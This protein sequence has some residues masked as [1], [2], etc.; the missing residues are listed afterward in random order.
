MGVTS[1]PVEHEQC[2]YSDLFGV[3][4]GLE[5]LELLRDAQVSPPELRS[6]CC[7]TE[8]PFRLLPA[9]TYLLIHQLSLLSLCLLP[10]CHILGIEARV[11]WPFL[12]LY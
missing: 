11:F 1:R 5:L 8:L 2:T 4:L 12:L 6:S 7:C 3:V 10:F 9:L